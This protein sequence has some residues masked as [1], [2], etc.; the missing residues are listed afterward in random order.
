MRNGVIAA[1]LLAGA[2]DFAAAAPGNGC[3]ADNCLRAL[4]ATQIPGRLESARAFC[5]SY[6]AV[7]SP[8]G[9]AVPSYAA[10]ACK[11]NQNADQ[12]AR[13]SSACACIA[14]AT[15]TT[16][17]PTTTPTTSPTANACAQ[18]SASWAS[19]KKTTA[20]PTVAAT[21]A[22]EC[23]ESVPL[24]KDA[25]IKLVD[26]LDYFYPGFD[27]F[28]N[29]AKVKANL[30]A[31]KYKSEYAFQADLYETVFG[32]GHDGHYVFYPDAL[33]KVLKWRRDR[34]LVSVSED[35]KS[36]P[37][38]KLYEDVVKDPKT[39]RVVS[40]INGIEASKYVEDTIVKATYNQDVDSAYNSMFYS[41]AISATN[42]LSGYFQ[43]GG[44]IGV[45]YQ[46]ANTTITFADGEDLTLENKANVIGDM[47]G[48]TDGP[49]FYKKFCTPSLRKKPLRRL[50][51]WQSSFPA[52]PSLSSRR[53]MASFEPRSPAEFQAV[54]QDFLEE[55]K[56]AGKTKLVVDF[57]V[58]GGGYILLGYD[59]F[60]Q[61]FPQV[62]EDGYSRWKE[63]GGFNAMSRIFS[64]AV[65]DLDPANSADGALINLYESW[66]NYRY[67]LNLTLDKF[68][69]FEDKFA[70]QVHKDTPYT[71]LMRWNLNDPLTTVNATFGMGIEISGYGTRK[72]LTQHF[73][74]EDIVLL[75]D[76]VCASTCTLASE[77]L[78]IQGGVKSVAFGGRPREGPIQGVGG[79]KGSQVL[80]FSNIL[81]YA[82]QAA[83]LTKDP[84]QLAELNRYTDLP[85]Q[86]SSAAAVNVRDQIL[87]DNV[88]DGLPAQFVAENADCR[89]YWTAP[90]ISDVSE[91]WKAAANSAFNGAKCANGGIKASKRSATA[92]APAVLSASRPPVGE[93][94][95][96]AR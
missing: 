67:D 52:T 1:A 11:K 78:R 9:V 70:P 63:N 84:K 48:V 6:T 17:T 29:L 60:R 83:E 5:A 22:H 75:Y 92:P 13:L 18:V 59:F 41:K 30:Q 58:N 81:D 4:R 27:L 15:T 93:R 31:D 68:S 53:P 57:Q 40:K 85:L 20:T 14:P 21:L 45:I 55:A 46:G 23:L 61:L 28:A 95:H 74:A 94:G 56:A 73:K 35:G 24:G 72:N 42:N 51:P 19:Q 38:I 49:S 82:Q 12:P 80:Q 10:D 79:V 89:L 66:F 37:V 36:L 91:I 90:M 54:T 16:A 96:D 43:S 87:R 77:M 86:R 71:S 34:S 33:T 8:T 7:P 39:A 69:T 26:S 47:T 32:P 2:A 65:K 62:Q 76:G 64:D 44:R 3:N 88:N 50:P 25:A